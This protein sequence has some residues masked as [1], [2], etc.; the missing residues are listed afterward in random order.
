VT[1]RDALVADPRV[2]AARAPAREVAALLSRP[3]VD[4]ALVVEGGRL[5]GCVTRESIVAA[6]A[7]GEDVRMLTARDLAD[8]DVTTI[9]PDAPLD[10]ALRVM[11]ERGLERLAV[12]QGGRLL[13]VVARE[14]LVRRIMEDEPPPADEE[15]AGVR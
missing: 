2:L 4:T 6:V 10:E 9:S 12:T 1:V 8:E 7:S 11:A 15:P 5:V 14:P 3:Q 13:G